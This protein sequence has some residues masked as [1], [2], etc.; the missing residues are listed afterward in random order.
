MPTSTVIAARNKKLSVVKVVGV[1]GS[2]KSTLVGCLRARGYDA[3]PV[4]QEHS[5][6]PDLWQRF[7]RP[8]ALIYLSVDVNELNNRRP[9]QSWTYADLAREQTRLRSARDAADLRLDTTNLLPNQTCDLVATFLDRIGAVHNDSPLE[10]LPATG[11]PR[12]RDSA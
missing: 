8:Y 6:V 9:G 2:G 1:S 4:S 7:E 11:T 3:R 12:P 5:D 10:R